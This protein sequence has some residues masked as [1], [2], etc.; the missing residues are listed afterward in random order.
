MQ[1]ILKKRFNSVAA[2]AAFFLAVG[3]VSSL[4]SCG[5]KLGPLSSEE[6][7]SDLPPTPENLTALVG[8]RSVRL[9]WEVSDSTTYSFKI[10]RSDSSNA[11]LELVDSATVRE[12]TDN[13]LVNGQSYFYQVSCVNAS[14]FEGYKSRRVEAVPDAFGILIENGSEFVNSIAVNLSLIAPLGTDHVMLS[15]DSAFTD[16]VWTNF[17][18][19]RSWFLT[20]GD[21]KKWVYAKFRDL[22][23]NPTLHY[24]HDSV[25]LDT[26]ASILRV[27]E[28][29]GGT[30]LEVGDTL[31]LLLESGETQGEASVD[32]GE[33]VT[34]IELYDDGSFGDSEADD[35]IYEHDYIIPTGLEAEEEP[36][37]GHFTDRA[38]NLATDL[39]G[40]GAVTIRNPP[41]AVHLFRPYAPPESRGV[42]VLHWS[43][44]DDQQFA[45]YSIY[46]STSSGVDLNSTLVTCLNDPGITT[47]TDSNLVE[48][49]YY[50]YVV[51]LFDNH[52][53]YSASNEDSARTGKN[54]AP[55][56]SVLYQ[57]Y[58][59]NWWT[60]HLS[61]SENEDADFANYQLFRG[62][63]SN[64]SDS[65]LIK[66]FAPRESTYYEDS[67]LTGDS[68]Y[69]YR[70]MTYDQ[71]GLYSASNLVS[72]T[73]LENMPPESSTLLT[74]RL[75]NSDS[76]KL[77]WSLNDE[78]D[79]ESY[80][81]YRLDGSDTASVGDDDL[82]LT[83][84]TDRE[85]GEFV[86]PDLTKGQSFSYRLYTHD[87]GG[88]SSRSNA[89]SYS[90]PLFKETG[91]KK[92]VTGDRR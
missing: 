38:G 43:R 54:S 34:G 82:L 87:K 55:Q 11:Q 3:L 63:Q 67:T 83:I 13:G 92:Q 27:G 62:G 4:S 65:I 22:L 10:Y 60:L 15:N 18:P 28:N 86:D 36:I 19:T 81:L 61:W 89:V 23:G 45:F 84:E 72:G 33:L 16:G 73:T 9:S 39:V 44:S 68:T 91:R 17:A 30:V 71:G 70:L 46:R 74:P 8:D 48:D 75:I 79:F 14:G 20:A 32:I 50:H 78:I 7:G 1:E 25:T 88:L 12:F 80:R 47:Y 24:Y 6:G 37:V 76:L 31:H 2:I 21:G 64:F 69:Y 42:M 59:E 90:V 57:P 26:K 56:P 85:S 35:G 53:L 58:G 66:V 5:R 40:T 29:S 77:T 49:L 41:D 51:Y 52:T